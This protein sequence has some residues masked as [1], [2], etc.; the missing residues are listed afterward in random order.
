MDE[1][2]TPSPGPMRQVVERSNSDVCGAGSAV[3]GMHRVPMNRCRRMV[4]DRAD[5]RRHRE[6]EAHQ[7]DD[8]PDCLDGHGTGIPHRPGLRG[9]LPMCRTESSL[10]VLMHVLTAFVKVV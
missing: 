2:D 1:A 3:A 7:G 4:L 8:Q 9:V 5:D 6:H 10:D